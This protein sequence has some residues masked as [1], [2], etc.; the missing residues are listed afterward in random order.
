MVASALHCWACRLA[1]SS[2]SVA[3]ISRRCAVAY[4][5]SALLTSDLAWLFGAGLCAAGR[6]G[7]VDPLP[8]PDR[9]GAY[10]LSG[11]ICTLAALAMNRRLM[12]SGSRRPSNSGNAPD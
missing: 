10:L 4:T 8:G 12:K 9:L 6:A 5:G 1:E 3:S 2:G 11:A 7:A